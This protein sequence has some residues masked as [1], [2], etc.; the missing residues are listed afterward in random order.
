MR[1]SGLCGPEG[2]E[3]VRVDLLSHDE[4]V[5]GSLS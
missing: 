4:D 5:P 1:S 2:Q 3:L